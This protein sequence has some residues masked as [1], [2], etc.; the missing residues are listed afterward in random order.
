MK[1]YLL[2]TTLLTF[3]YTQQAFCEDKP[4]Q[5]SEYTYPAVEV[6]SQFSDRVFQNP[7]KKLLNC[8]SLFD[9]NWSYPN[10]SSIALC[11]DAQL[12]CL[13]YGL[14]IQK[15][16]KNQGKN[17][18]G[19]QKALALSKEEVTLRLHGCYLA[20][21]ETT[22]GEQTLQEAAGYPMDPAQQK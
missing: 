19:Y 8:P 1:P 14:I 9:N 20:L 10:G 3:T 22:V 21:D 13:R 16:K 5:K 12:A 7:E 18:P 2:F 17:L 15:L 6:S 11:D 4:P